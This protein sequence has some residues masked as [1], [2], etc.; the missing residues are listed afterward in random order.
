MARLEQVIRHTLAT[1][2][3]CVVIFFDL[4]NAYDNI[5]HMGLLYKLSRM[6]VRGRLLHW[7]QEFLSE[8]I[9]GEF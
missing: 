3:Y 6:G 5:F 2:A 1:R 8:N 9:L 4:S 7:L